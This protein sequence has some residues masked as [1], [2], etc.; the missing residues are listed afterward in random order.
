MVRR[1]EHITGEDMMRKFDLFGLEKGV[2]VEG[3]YLLSPAI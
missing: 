2:G 1:L 3:V